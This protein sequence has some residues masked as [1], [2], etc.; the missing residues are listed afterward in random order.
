MPLWSFY[1]FLAAAVAAV[2]LLIV[3]QIYNLLVNLDWA[4][5]ARKKYLYLRWIFQGL[6]MTLRI[7]AVSMV[8][9]LILGTIIG[10]GRLSNSR[11]IRAFCTPYVEFF[12]NTPL[13]IQ[14][15]FWYFGTS[16]LLD[17]MAALIGLGHGIAPGL[18]GF[19]KENIYALKDLYNKGQS[20]FISGVVGLTI[21]TSAFI[22]EVVRA[23][24][25]AIPHG[26]TEAAR[27]TGLNKGQTLWYV[28]LPQAFRII[29]PPLLSQFLAL[30]KNSSQAMAIGV[31]EVTYMAR[32]VEANTFKG[33]E[34]FTVATA[35][36]MA[37]SFIMSYLLNRYDKSISIAEMVRKKQKM[38][39]T[40][41]V[42]LSYRLGRVFSIVAAASGMAV[43][44]LAWK[45]AGGGSWMMAV[46]LFLAGFAA[47]AAAL[48]AVWRPEWGVGFIHGVLVLGATAV[49]FDL[50]GRL[51]AGLMSFEDPAGMI[52]IPLAW[53]AL[54]GIFTAFWWKYFRRRE[55]L[56]I[57]GIKR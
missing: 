25:Q 34:A 28:I 43:F 11:L 26:Q 46:L 30:T 49:F 16:A 14:L 38:I 4:I 29:I 37:I 21:Y 44:F 12:R 35:L 56:F 48:V 20:E 13:L 52:L 10:I 27:A 22:A 55:F 3:P 47:L 8:L 24:I 41:T 57:E 9:A 31:A 54:Y 40:R 6:V 53:T 7:S 23:G 33:F 5:F 45:A 39:R 36:Y 51:D 18:V 50:L 32:Q 19:L 2:L 17:A 1:A 15:F 42:A